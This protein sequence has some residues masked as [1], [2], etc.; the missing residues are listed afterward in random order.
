LPEFL[1]CKVLLLGDEAVGKT[2]LI[3]R[4]VVDNF[5]DRY[6]TTIGAKITKK[7]VRVES[8]KSSCELNMIIWDILGQKGFNAAQANSFLG[9]RGVVLVYDSSRPSTGDSLRDYWVPRLKEVSG[10]VPLMLFS[11]KIDLVAERSSAIGMARNLAA[12]LGCV[13]YLTSAK[14][15]ENVEPGFRSLAKEMIGVAERDVRALTGILPL[16][17][18]TSTI[19]VADR[20]M[21]DFC[22]DFGGIETGSPILKKQFSKAG[23]DIRNPT[24]DGLLDAIELLAEVEK[25]FKPSSDVEKKRAKWI[26]WV[27]EI[28]K[29]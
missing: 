14:T 12:D 18:Q 11:N 3:S 8:G 9:S 25:S 16:P 4:F 5:S 27:K 29:P 15:G 17:F 21:V 28:K 22:N 10:S 6:L 20:I 19:D 24:A 7:D 1:K 2:S 26:E 13:F 23:L